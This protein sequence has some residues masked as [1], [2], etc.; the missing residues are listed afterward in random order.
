MRRLHRW[1]R[2]AL[3]VSVISLLACGFPSLAIPIRG[4][5]QSPPTLASTAQIQESAVPSSVVPPS[6]EPRQATASPT[7][8]PSPIP[9]PTLAYPVSLETPYP[10]PSHILQE[11]TISQMR[12]LARFGR[13]VASD[14][15]YYPPEHRIIVASTDGVV[16][17][18]A[19]RLVEVDFWPTTKPALALALSPDG[20]LLAVG[21]GDQVLLWDIAQRRVVRVLDMVEEGDKPPQSSKPEEQPDQRPTERWITAL[22]FSPNGVWVAAGAKYRLAVWEVSTG[23]LYR[24]EG[25]EILRPTWVDVLRFSQEGRYLMVGNGKD[26]ILFQLE[27]W[28]RNVPPELMLSQSD[29]KN[30]YYFG[31]KV[32]FYELGNGYVQQVARSPDGRFFAAGYS[33]GVVLVWDTEH[34][35]R[36]NHALV[37]PWRY[38]WPRKDPVVALEFLDEH[39][40]AFISG[41]HFEV[42]DV[43]AEEEE[44]QI[45]DHTLDFTPLLATFAGG[46]EWIMIDSIGRVVR[47]VSEGAQ[48]TFS[49]PEFSF[50]VYDAA[51]LPNG[52][53]VILAGWSP[54][55]VI[56][57]VVNGKITRRLHIEGAALPLTSVGVSPDLAWVTAVDWKGVIWRYDL[58]ENQ[59]EQLDV[60]PVRYDFAW[61]MA[62]SP[63]G[64]MLAIGTWWM[65][66]YIWD[67][68][69]NALHR[70]FEH[71]PGTIAR[72]AF[73][74]TGTYL[75][76]ASV[77]QVIIWD[78]ASGEVV[79]TLTKNTKPTMGWV[80]DVAW[81]PIESTLLLSGSNDERWRLWKIGENEPLV[82]SE[83]VGERVS[84]VAW[85]PD[86]RLAAVG[87][88]TT[89]SIWDVATGTLLAS[90]DWFFDNDGE[91]ITI[92]EVP[93]PTATLT[94]TTTP[95]LAD[96]LATIPPSEA[97]A[98]GMSK[99][100]LRHM[101]AWL[102]LLTFAL[103]GRVVVAVSADG[104]MRVWG[105]R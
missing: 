19:N 53:E 80:N 76:G 74:P 102:P 56:R 45:I 40:L 25:L 78:T 33:S 42:R 36:G 83:P 65:A 47:F 61:S 15:L 14:V 96:P 95:T 97:V 86:G 41:A 48:A 46:D 3:W 62:V 77:N 1:H 43:T 23:Q 10:T 101:Y 63:A 71:L 75:A 44:E 72:L 67:M 11:D 39:T 28:K 18:D 55:L 30:Q 79:Q 50:W 85:S 60:L 49:V 16:W 51:L 73:S 29:S 2:V 13:G 82:V 35:F 58:E 87:A 66:A 52:R 37:S 34:P 99:K 90:T 9:T 84:R 21:A 20:R 98:R 5:N 57:D 7:W 88:L 81:N 24:A 91:R 92:G 70:S 27:P 8:T 100:E 104:V 103:D 59:A 64:G 4:T 93:S 94:P 6:Y 12:L 32:T 31:G 22:A 54:D 89:V 105:V 17:Y 68:G 69:R 26:V 38:W